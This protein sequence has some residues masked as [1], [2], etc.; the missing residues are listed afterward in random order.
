M[1]PVKM[2]GSAKATSRVTLSDVE[3]QSGHKFYNQNGAYLKDV[4][5]FDI[6]DY[7][8]SSTFENEL[9]NSNHPKTILGGVNDDMQTLKSQTGI[10]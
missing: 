5:P 10:K 3:D 7:E 9:E 1:N 6:P 2:I 4:G 8:I